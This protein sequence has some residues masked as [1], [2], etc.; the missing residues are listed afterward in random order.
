MLPSEVPVNPPFVSCE[1]LTEV[2]HLIDMCMSPRRGDFVVRD[3]IPDD[4][5]ILK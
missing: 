5:V 1:K 3:V 2:C 4:E